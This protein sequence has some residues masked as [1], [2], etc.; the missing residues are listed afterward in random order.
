[1]LAPEPISNDNISAG[2]SESIK[3]AASGPI[4]NC[5]YDD[6]AVSII[7]NPLRGEI[8]NI[9]QIINEAGL[10]ISWVQK[11]RESLEGAKGALGK[12]RDYIREIN[13]F[14]NSEEEK[15][16]LWG[17]VKSVAK[18][19]NEMLARIERDGR[20]MLSVDGE[21]VS[22]PVGDGSTVG[23]IADNLR[24][25]VEDLNVFG[26]SRSM[27][28]K[29]VEAMEAI[30]AFDGFLIGVSQRIEKVT[31]HVQF[32][33][34]EILDVVEN[35]KERNRNLEIDFYSLTQM[36]DRAYEAMRS[37]ANIEPETAVELLM[38]PIGSTDE[39]RMLEDILAES[40]E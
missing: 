34:E 12:M 27:I 11:L 14:K 3:A 33:L 19:Y 6:A 10:A 38:D 29:L 37:Q 13:S 23:I 20:K 16:K 17:E 26:N 25:D 36:L 18:D 2:I 15:V 30:R 39:D 28:E 5:E 31:T 1:M 21:T 8:A 35:I 32:E 7:Q 9:R 4:T 40:T 22:M 24:F